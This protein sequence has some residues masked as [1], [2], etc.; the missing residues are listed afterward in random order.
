[1]ASGRHHELMA[2][3]GASGGRG[4]VKELGGGQQVLCP[5]VSRYFLDRICHRVDIGPAW[6]GGRGARGA[7]P[8]GSP[9]RCWALRR[10]MRVLFRLS[11]M[12]FLEYIA[13]I[14]LFGV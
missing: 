3:E 9:Y 13:N 4:G 10:K 7:G 8:S 5:V 6:E 2:E 1:M 12:V 11:N 14:K